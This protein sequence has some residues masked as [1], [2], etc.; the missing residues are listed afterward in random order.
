[1]INFNKKD[2]VAEEVTKILAQEAELSHKQKRIAALAGDKKAIDALDLAALRA[3][4][5]PVDVEEG[6][7]EMDKYLKDKEKEKGTGKFEKKKISTGTVYQKKHNAPKEDEKD[8]MKEE[9]EQIDESAKWRDP[10]Y[11][12]RLYTQKPGDSDDYDNIGY[13]HEVPKRPEKN[14]PGQKRRMGGIGDKRYRTDPLETGFG[15]TGIKH[16]IIDTGKR[17]GLPSRDQ[18]RSLKGSIKNAHGKHHAPNLPEQMNESVE[19][20]DMLALNKKLNG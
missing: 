6:F 20:N 12:D 10:K 7:G 5:K 4:K 16:N 8:D 1:M 19:L 13:G 3:G 14:D 15:R 2:S 11:K 17:K 18:V 9:V